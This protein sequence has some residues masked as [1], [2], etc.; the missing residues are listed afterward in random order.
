VDKSKT[1]KM[2]SIYK[3]LGGVIQMPEFC[4][5][6][7]Y[8]HKTKMNDINFPPEFKDYEQTIDDV[9]KRVVDRGN[10]CYVTIDEKH[11]KGETHRR[12][13]IHCDFNWYEGEQKHGTGGSH[14]RTGWDVPDG[15]KFK[16]IEGGGMLLVSNYE[17]CRVW[18]GEFD[19]EIGEGGD[20]SNIDVSNLKNEMMPSGFV[21][22]LNA[23]GIHESVFI[24][25]DVNRSLIRINFH[26]EY[27]FN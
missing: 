9:L 7:L 24:D 5:R 12:G 23:L 11:I 8:M 3:N 6:K 15:W 4:E 26:P 27:H 18:G 2:K 25:K 19:G 16:D 17:G 10:V 21:Y 14:K 1:I 22:Y 13:G 20:C